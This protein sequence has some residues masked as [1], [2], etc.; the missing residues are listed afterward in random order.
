MNDESTFYDSDSADQLNGETS[1]EVSI[2]L[3]RFIFWL[4]RGRWKILAA[5]VVSGVFGYFVS[6]WVDPTYRAHAK[7]IFDAREEALTSGVTRGPGDAEILQNEIEI[8]RSRPLVERVVRETH[9]VLDPTFNPFVLPEQTTPFSRLFGTS[10]VRETAS[11]QTAQKGVP[12]ASPDQPVILNSPVEA[13]V[14]PVTYPA[15]ERDMLRQERRVVDLVLE[16]LRLEPVPASRVLQI[17]F[18]AQDAELSARV[19][20]AFAAAYIAET[21]DLRLD[22]M[23]GATEWL[24]DRVEALRDQVRIAEDKVETARAD[25]AIRAAITAQQLEAQNATILQL[26]N[27]MRRAQMSYQRLRDAGPEG[28]EIGALPEYSQSEFLDA[29]RAQE[30]EITIQR[31]DLLES[32]QESHL[33]VARANEALA[34][35]R[36]ARQKESARIIEAAR[37]EW[38]ALKEEETALRESIIT[39][40]NEARTQ[41]QELVEIRQ[42][43]READVRRRVYETFLGRLSETAEQSKFDSSNARVLSAAVAPLLPIAH[44][45]K[46]ALIICMLLGLAAGILWLY[47]SERLSNT[48][49]SADEI[50]AL[51]RERVLAT[52]PA[53][54]NRM[55][56]MPF[57]RMLADSDSKQVSEVARML[58]T[59]VLYRRRS[60][61]PKIIMLTSTLPGE[62]KSTLAS[63][64][65]MSLAQ[66]G[67]QTALIDGDLRDPSIKEL[68]G[69]ETDA[70]DILS[71]LDS[72]S[73]PEDIISRHEP[74]GLDI[75]RIGT[76]EMNYQ[77]S[78]DLLSTKKFR[79]VLNILGQSY[80]HV[81]IDAPPAEA[82]ADA[83]IL[84][85]HVDALV[86]VVRYGDTPRD[87][88]IDC[89][90]RLKEIGAPVAGIVLTHAKGQAAASMS[91]QDYGFSPLLRP[92]DSAVQA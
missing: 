33:L 61:Q 34:D 18:A 4:W 66:I 57:L 58:R 70:A 90:K 92:V 55:A 41:S 24:D 82:V 42:L 72:K 86:Y 21:I 38:L 60:K 53:F 44:V 68:F 67:R 80:D 78:A 76:D 15:I 9:L 11:T 31:A 3:R 51:T 87:K 63:V 59:N 27:E 84:A 75:Y 46:R 79:T 20:N 26:H 37:L 12:L 30:A 81:I 69:L 2:D 43:E 48:F 49:H 54:S 50:E 62:G 25:Q 5:L 29:L 83:W 65:A 13:G 40:Q 14:T 39:L 19:A 85:K 32:V 23:Q 64:L 74:S 7:V 35:I 73:D 89:L 45:K 16:N 1:R 88:V 56:R 52:L 10:R 28:A 6:H 91:V 36:N 71:L 17:S 77:N 47:L 8:L 22:A